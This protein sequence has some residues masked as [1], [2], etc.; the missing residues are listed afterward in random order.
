M[1]F[2]ASRD[3]LEAAAAVYYPGRSW[4]IENVAFGD[5]VLRLLV[6]DEREI[7]TKLLFLDMHQPLAP[8]EIEGK[9][10]QGRYVR[11]VV[12]EVIEADAWCPFAYPQNGLAPFVD[13]S[14]FSSF[15]AYREWLLSRHRGQIRDRERRWRKLAAEHGELV[16]TADDLAADVVPSALAWK[17]RQLQL[18]GH[19]NYC[20]KPETAAFL[21]ALRA[22]GRLMSSTL[23]AAGRLVSVWIGFIHEGSWS[24]WVFTYD[25]AFQ[26]YSAGHRLVMGLLEESFKRGHREFDFSE[27]AEDYKFVYATHGRL[28][29]DI[30][31]PP[32]GRRIVKLAKSAFNRAGLLPA[33]QRI[34]RHLTGVLQGQSLLPERS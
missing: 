3:Y 25:P 24:G 8:S 31:R 14:G 2:Y 32:L 26:K 11:S 27:G 29:G 28:L 15:A 33:A 20:E 23:R 4:A 6:L 10:R 16:F 21:D 19:S 9:M 34:K 1:N 17:S 7:V 30:G 22:R 5:E 12:R 13:W 18:T